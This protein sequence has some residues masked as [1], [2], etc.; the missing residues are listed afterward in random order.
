[1]RFDPDKSEG[2]CAAI[3]CGGL[4]RAAMTM[5]PRPAGRR[6]CRQRRRQGSPPCSCRVAPRR[7]RGRR[8]SRPKRPR[9]GCRSSA[10]ASVVRAPVVM[11]GGSATLCCSQRSELGS[12]SPPLTAGSVISTLPS[13][14][15][16][17][18]KFEIAYLPTSRFPPPSFRRS[19]PSA[20]RWW[21]TRRCRWG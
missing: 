4:T 5:W 6:R 11:P 2:R 16:L 17:T 13:L 20:C 19:S 12:A 14:A 15:A 9:A 1:M 10:P 3:W 8:R 21:W 7:R 18:L